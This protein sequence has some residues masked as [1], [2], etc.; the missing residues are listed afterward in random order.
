VARDE[1][2]DLLHRIP[3][4]NGFDRTRIKRLGELADEVEVPPGKVLMRQGEE[5]EDMMVIV[6]GRVAIERDGGRL[7]T[8]GPGDFFGEIAMVAHGPR[9]ATATTEEPSTLLVVNH[10]D[11]HSLMEEFPEVADQVLHAL[12]QRLRNLDPDSC[13]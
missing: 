1:K 7:N 11:F 3:L 13:N 9:T 6:R 2:L 5:G 8:M 4:F 10:R 12:A